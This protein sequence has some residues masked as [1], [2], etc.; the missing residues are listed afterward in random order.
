MLVPSRA[1]CENALYPFVVKG[2]GKRFAGVHA[3]DTQLSMTISS[4]A[5][6][7]PGWQGAE[8]FLSVAQVG[9]TVKSTL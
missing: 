7:Q 3:L 6:S 2:E 1:T 4:M 9:T 5:Q 8:A